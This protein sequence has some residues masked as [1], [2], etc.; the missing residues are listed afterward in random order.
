MIHLTYNSPHCIVALDAYFTQKH[1]K[2]IQDSKQHHPYD[3]FI[4]KTQVKA[5]EEY[6]ES[7]GGPDH[8]KPAKQKEESKQSQLQGIKD[9]GFD[10]STLKVPYSVLDSCQE[11][12]TAADEARTKSSIKVLG[13]WL[14]SV[15]ITVL[16]GWKIWLLQERSKSIH[17][18]YLRCYFNI[19]HSIGRRH[20]I[21]HY[22]HSWVDMSSVG[23]FRL[24]YCLNALHGIC[25]VP[26]GH[27]KLYTIHGSVLDSKPQI[28]NA[29]N[30]FGS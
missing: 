8:T 22:V 4:P 28:E 3:S 20:I 2:Q 21:W 19:S 1:N 18:C 24:L 6:I 23:V 10:H 7:V 29:V 15:A 25:S 16:A 26:D 5:M 27:A 30:D 14:S 9:D 13:L 12:F 17:W 11:S